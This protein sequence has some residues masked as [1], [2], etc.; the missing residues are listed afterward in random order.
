MPARRREGRLVDRGLWDVPPGG[1]VGRLS[2]SLGGGLRGV[3]RP[4]GFVQPRLPCEHQ[5]PTPCA[6]QNVGGVGPETSDSRRGV[7]PEVSAQSVFYPPG[8]AGVGYPPASRE[9]V[10]AVPP[11]ITYSALKVSEEPVPPQKIHA[12]GARHPPRRGT[13]RPASRLTFL[14]PTQAFEEAEG[15]RRMSPFN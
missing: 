10:D 12:E 2:R 14:D 3:G 4:V 8:G 9:E 7:A 15:V 1:W 11:H 13:A 5:R 6:R